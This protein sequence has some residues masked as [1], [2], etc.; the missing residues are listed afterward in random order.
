MDKELRVRF[1]PSPTGNLH[2]GGLRT[3]LFDW[4]LAKKHKGCFILRIEDTDQQREVKGSVD[5]IIEA[6]RWAGLDYDEGPD[7]DGGHGPYFQS[8][9]LDIYHDHA[10]R[11]LAED[12]AYYCFCSPER[13]EK[14][15]Q[16][17]QAQK[18]APRYDQLCRSLSASE[19]KK[20]AEAGEN[21]VI[22]MKL[23]GQGTQ[24]LRDLIR[25]DVDFS[26]A[27][28]DDAVIMKSDGF[29]TYQLA[30]VVDDHLMEISHVLRAEEWL[31]SAPKHLWL[32]QAF[33]WEAPLYA[34]L[35]L[36]LNPAGG[37][38]SK[39]DAA[40]S[41]FEYRDQG[42]LPE[43]LLNF[44]AFLGWNPKTE[45]EFFTI[46]ELI[47]SFEL[48]KVNKAGAV[49]NIDKLNHINGRYI[50]Q[51]PTSALVEKL[52]PYFQSVSVPTDDE[53]RLH[54]ITELIKDRLVKLTDAGDLAAF[55]V[56]PIDYDGD[57]LV[58]KKGNKETTIERLK[59]S[60]QIFSEI[61]A[62]DYTKE[63][64]YNFFLNKI[65][66]LG[67]KT[68]EILWPLRVALAGQANSPG[69]FEI[70]E[71]L[72]KEEAMKRVETALGKL[73]DSI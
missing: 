24:R 49:F 73:N 16:Q 28:Q 59:Q 52:K 17:Q 2:I 65:S 23:P 12:K 47:Q 1:A 18:L 38:L 55:L 54:K 56:S 30:N 71:I 64:L 34:H 62:G 29:P 7:K 3:A 27:T 50:R 10:Q 25:G 35:P 6:L 53:A 26:F 31:P 33:G 44:V 21:A 58:P 57:I 5:G 66:A 46:D 45:Q 70:T 60:L 9:R 61:E 69:V 22:R 40:V 43:A 11:L 32:Y 36:I 37:K 48:E 63:N 8:Q 20:K 14:V 51:M 15:R 68:G 19:A 39:R 42:Y 67:V 72:G 13:L 41:V 4:L